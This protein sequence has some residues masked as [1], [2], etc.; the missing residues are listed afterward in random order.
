MTV[1]GVGDSVSAS[2]R[3]TCSD[4]TF[5]GQ[6]TV[7]GQTPSRA[8]AARIGSGVDGIVVEGPARRGR[9]GAGDCLGHLGVITARASN[10]ERRSPPRPWARGRAAPG[11]GPTQERRWAA[12]LWPRWGGPRSVVATAL[13]WWSWSTYGE[14]CSIGLESECPPQNGQKWRCPSSRGI[15]ENRVQERRRRGWSPR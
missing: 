6:S 3:K 8:H 7:N 2:E 11:V 13:W 15:P 4:Q 10:V 1:I 12:T 5:A 14:K 9:G